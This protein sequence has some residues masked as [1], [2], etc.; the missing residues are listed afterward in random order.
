MERN[1]AMEA[2]AKAVAAHTA[3]LGIDDDGDPVRVGMWHLLRSLHEYAGTV[4]VPFEDC[5]PQGTKPGEREKRLYLVKVVSVPGP[6][7]VAAAMTEYE[8]EVRASSVEKACRMVLS[9]PVRDPDVAPRTAYRA[10]T[11]EYIAP[12]WDRYAMAAQIRMGHAEDISDAVGRAFRTGFAPRP[13]FPSAATAEQERL[14]S[15]DPVA[16]AGL[17]LG[18]AGFE[19]GSVDGVRQALSSLRTYSD[20]AGVEFGDVV[21]DVIEDVRAVGPAMR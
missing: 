8:F 13:Y 17:A 20:R 11:Q 10:Y 7:T 2:A 18:A 3:A 12:D 15:F 6:V 21:E 5:L 14:E 9:G 19:T 16:A 4:G 1:D